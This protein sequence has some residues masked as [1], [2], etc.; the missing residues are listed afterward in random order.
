MTKDQSGTWE[1]ESNENFEG[2]MKALGKREK[3]W[4]GK[5]HEQS[6]LVLQ[7]VLGWDSPELCANPLSSVITVQSQLRHMH[8]LRLIPYLEIINVVGLECP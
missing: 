4:G 3:G 1:M 2:Y 5:R 7:E 6:R 8:S